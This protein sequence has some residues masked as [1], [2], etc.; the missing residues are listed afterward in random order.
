M[1]NKLLILVLIVLVCG[2]LFSETAETEVVDIADQVVLV[3]TMP[4]ENVIDVY[5]KMSRWL[6][7]S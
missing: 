3:R 2:P 4:S 7:N 1:K 5:G 6:E